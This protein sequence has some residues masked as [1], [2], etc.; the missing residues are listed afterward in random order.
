ML[1]PNPPRKLRPAQ[2]CRGENV[3]SQPPGKQD[4]PM[5]HS[6]LG[7]GLALMTPFAD[8]RRA[9]A[10]ERYDAAKKCDEPNAEYGQAENGVK[11][12]VP[13]F[14]VGRPLVG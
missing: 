1:K 3:I 6:S 5:A 10:H 7:N 12:L 13:D 9:V 4:T 14:L 8:Q 11:H 2:R